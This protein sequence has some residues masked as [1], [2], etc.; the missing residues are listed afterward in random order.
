MSAYGG[1][2]C[3]TENGLRRSSTAPNSEWTFE[4]DQLPTAHATVVRREWDRM[5]SSGSAAREQ[6]AVRSALADRRELTTSLV[7]TA[8]TPAIG[9]LRAT[10]TG[11]LWSY[12]H[13]QVP[14]REAVT[15]ADPE[16]YLRNSLGTIRAR[17]PRTVNFTLV[18]GDAGPI[19]ESPCYCNG[20][21]RTT[22]RTG[23]AITRA[24]VWERFIYDHDADLHFTDP[25]DTARGSDIRGFVVDNGIVQVKGVTQTPFTGAACAN[26]VDV[27]HNGS[28]TSGELPGQRRGRQPRTLLRPPN[29]AF[30]FTVTPVNDK[31]PRRSSHRTAGMRRLRSA[32]G[33]HDGVPQGRRLSRPPSPT[34][35]Y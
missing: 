28:E 14:I 11:R 13:Q 25:D 31:K 34:P 32:R 30:Q 7:E 21:P 19:P 23:P 26:E 20:L 2:L 9:T 29:T 33:E 4:L 17:S 6:E 27:R 8:N 18:D 1:N 3:Y 10:R 12:L 24:T 15:G 35:T 22:R 5:I 16:N